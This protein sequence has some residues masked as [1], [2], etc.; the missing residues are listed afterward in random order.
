MRRAVGDKGWRG[1]FQNWIIL[2]QAGLEGW[3]K[4]SP[5]ENCTR[6]Q[7]TFGEHPICARP[8]DGCFVVPALRGAQS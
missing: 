3:T 4:L 5:M 7:R 8:E 6:M 1:N 2:Y